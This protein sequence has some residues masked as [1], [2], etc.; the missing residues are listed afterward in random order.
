MM[1][2]FAA[3]NSSVKLSGV[4]NLSYIG[5]EI[6]IEFRDDFECKNHLHS[7]VGPM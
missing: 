5:V 7:N 2:V 4:V 1:V 3:F 6:F